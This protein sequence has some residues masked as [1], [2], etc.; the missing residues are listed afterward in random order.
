[1]KHPLIK[2]FCGGSRG[3]VFSKRVPLAA[4]AGRAALEGEIFPFLVGYS[5][6]PEV[7]VYIRKSCPQTRIF[8]SYEFELKYKRSVL[9]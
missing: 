2:S 1:M 4:G 5:F 3:A 7:E 8:K 6:D 9:Q